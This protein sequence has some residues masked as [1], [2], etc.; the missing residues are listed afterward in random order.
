MGKRK[1][2]WVRWLWKWA[3]GNLWEVRRC[4]YPYP[5]GTFA[6]YLPSKR[7]VLDTGLTRDEAAA[8]CRE[9]NG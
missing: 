6:T 2:K 8:L 7:M 1:L 3:R 5:R 9:L 4:E